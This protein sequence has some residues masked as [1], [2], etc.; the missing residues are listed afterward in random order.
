MGQTLFFSSAYAKATVDK[1][2]K[3]RSDPF[4]TRHNFFGRVLV[5]GEDASYFRILN[6]HREILHLRK[7]LCFKE[8]IRRVKSGGYAKDW[9]SSR[10]AESLREDE[11]YFEVISNIASSFFES[12]VE[13]IVPLLPVNTDSD[14][15]LPS[16]LY[17]L[18]A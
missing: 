6:K 13:L 12:L 16:S 17:V 7:A 14:T 5:Y 4:T 11:Y 9:E 15:T 3:N 8:I 10:K 2:R 18:T 1:S